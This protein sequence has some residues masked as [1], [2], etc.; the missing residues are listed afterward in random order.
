LSTKSGVNLGFSEVQISTFGIDFVGC[1]TITSA[2][3]YRFFPNFVWCSKMK[4]A[5]RPLFMRQTGS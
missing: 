4:P 1:R 5:R 2:V 3:L